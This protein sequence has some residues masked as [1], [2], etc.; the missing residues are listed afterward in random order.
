MV[1]AEPSWPSGVMAASG[2]ATPRMPPARCLDLGWVGGYSLDAMKTTPDK[3][4]PSILSGIQPTG[5]LT[6]GNYL[7]ALRNW[8]ALQD[9]Y[10]CYYVLVD[11]H[12]ITV[13]QD[14]KVL[15]RRCYEFLALYMACGLDPATSTLF[16][17]SHVPTHAQLSWI[18]N[19]FTYMGEAQ[20]MTQFKEKSSRH[21]ENINIGL[22]D[23]P[24]LMAADI[25]LYSADL[26]PVGEDQK[27]HLELTRNL[28]ERFNGI[29]GNVFTVPEPFIPKVGARI[30]SLKDPTSKM[31]K[32]DEDDATYVA[33]LD[34]PE[35]V[36]RKIKRAV[37]DAGREVVYD[38]SRPGLANLLTIF[39][40]TAG[41]PIE[42]IVGR[43]EGKGYGDLKKEL[44]EAIVEF[45]RPVQQR[46]RDI[47]ADEPGLARVLADG[48]ARALARTRPLL[49]RVHE[50]LGFIPE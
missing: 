15:R 28:A 32:T 4:K 13:R 24:V 40:A 18:L 41:E 50:A 25:L 36:R 14:P 2:H 37:T 29:Y 44:A 48:A 12:A 6:I 31:S 35:A 33:L 27:Q 16:V 20:R 23:Y 38:E 39:A 7:G 17:Q 5:R 43:Y 45:L 19:C 26:V 9:Q 46:Y 10:E 8:V 34:E 49:A 47:I 30:M 22:F 11:L 21:S 3:R 42:T 1:R